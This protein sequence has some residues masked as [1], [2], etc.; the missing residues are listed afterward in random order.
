MISTLIVLRS[1]IA[2]RMPHIL[3]KTFEEGIRSNLSFS[4]NE[5]LPNGT[6]QLTEVNSIFP[7]TQNGNLGPV[8]QHACAS[9]PYC[10]ALNL[11]ISVILQ[12]FNTYR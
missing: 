1:G 10:S 2:S 8:F 12:T 7:R 3:R 11:F 6:V 9:S 4:M 5:Q